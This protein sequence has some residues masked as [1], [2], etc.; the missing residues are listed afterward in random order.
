[1]IKTTILTLISTLIKILSS[2]VINKTVSVYIGPSG[3][4]LIG[5]FQN[6]LQIM[7]VV[8][9]GGI[10][11]GIIKYTAEYRD[12]NNK[13]HSVWSAGAAILLS[14]S[15]IIGFISIVFSGFLSKTILKSDEYTYVFILLG[16]TVFLFSLNQFFLSI[17]NGLKKIN[18]FVFVNI[19][20]SI[21]SLI[22]TSLLIIFFRFDG[23]LIALVTNQSIV[24]FVLMYKVWK[25]KEIEFSYFFSHFNNESFAKLAK[26]SLMTF[27]SAMTMPAAIFYIRDYIG[28]NLSW[29]DAGYWQGMWYISSTYLMVVTTALSTYFLP[30]LSELKSNE[31]IKKEFI[32]G[33]MVIIP[34]L[35]C[36]S[37][38]IFLLKDFIVSFLFTHDF[39]PMVNLFKWQLIGDVIKMMSWLMS[40][41][42]LAK[43]MTKI[44]IASEF[45]F[46][47]SFVLLSILFIN[48]YGLVG[49]TY[50]YFINY[51][52][53]LIFMLVITT[54]KLRC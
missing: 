43:A 26:Y 54:K 42:V 9:Q 50:G 48:K 28:N 47:L 37:F 30:R 34:L 46:S 8:A 33:Y 21:Y 1:M 39:Y 51:L 29:N 52:F 2:L 32:Q 11:N 15:F 49:V 25:I 17:I 53:Y 24:F 36:I 19:S 23:A 45:M 27:V 40:Y 22:I 13:L 7:M 35:I 18:I 20:Q 41:F 10:N 4:A 12:D 6:L 38:S 5:Q 44:Y 16:V 31:D 3:L 14:S